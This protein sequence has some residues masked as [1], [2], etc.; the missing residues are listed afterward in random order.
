MT[1]FLFL[2]LIISYSVSSQSLKKAYKF[3][4]KGEINKFKDALKNLS[5]INHDKFI[6]KIFLLNILNNFL[7]SFLF[8]FV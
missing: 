8:F 5:N 1:R 6:L 7:F 3:Y 2:L 4:E